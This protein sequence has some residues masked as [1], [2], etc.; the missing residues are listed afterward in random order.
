MRRLE[1]LLPARVEPA[2]SSDARAGYSLIEVLAASALLAG[3]LLAIMGMFVYGGQSVNAGKLMTKA[4]SISNDVLEQFRQLSFRQSYN[5]IEDGGVPGTDT[6]YIWQ[7]WTNTPN[8]PDEASYQAMLADWKSQ[9][10]TGLPMGQ[11]IISIRGLQDLGSN[12]PEQ[13]FGTSRVLQITVTVKWT[14]R[15]RQRS[16]VFETL[17]V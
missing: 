13:A 7:S 6:H 1:R 15:R 16:V 5:L 4:T 8:Y 2:A 12:P 9:V 3:V 14:E 17:K 11:M 10:E